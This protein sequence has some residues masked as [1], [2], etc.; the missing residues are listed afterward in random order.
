[1]SASCGGRSDLLTEEDGVAVLTGGTGAA[2]GQPGVTGGVGGPVG[3]GGVSG[4]GGG[5]GGTLVAGTGAYAGGGI[6]GSPGGPCFSGSF[7]RNYPDGSQNCVPWSD[8]LPGERVVGWPTAEWDRECAVCE[9]GYTVTY[10]ATYCEAWRACTIG[11]KVGEPGS[12]TSDVSCIDAEVFPIHRPVMGGALVAAAA[13]A[14]AVY[15][16][17][18][19]GPYGA[20]ELVRYTLDG[21]LKTSAVSPPGTTIDALGAQGASLFIAGTRG[22]PLSFGSQRIPY[23]TKLD[24]TGSPLWTLDLEP[25]GYGFSARVTS[26][27]SELSVAWLR[28]EVVCEPYPQDPDYQTCSPIGD[29]VFVVGRYDFDGALLLRKEHPLGFSP[30]AISDVEVTSDGRLFLNFSQLGTIVYELDPDLELVHEFSTQDLGG[31]SPVLAKNPAGQVFV[32]GSWAGYGNDP[33]WGAFVG[34][35]GGV[36][37]YSVT[38]SLVGYYDWF[39]DLGVTADGFYLGGHLDSS[40][41][42]VFVKLDPNGALVAREV[43]GGT[44]FETVSRLAVAPDGSVFAAG[45]SYSATSQVFVTPWPE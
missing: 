41:D 30:P 29:L 12:P 35:F 19:D 11:E 33:S 28:R 5:V 13:T 27:G 44:D 37:E 45:S 2:G 4:G 38:A 31:Y 36:G 40:S 22:D 16:G 34:V 25:D 21:T 14:S 9:E 23:L 18:A 20:S 32:L 15:L 1:M 42:A 6:G 26:S 43:V 7:D 17:V 39:F 10:N 24:E 3:A 8:C